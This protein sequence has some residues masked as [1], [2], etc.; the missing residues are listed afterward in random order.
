MVRALGC[1]TNSIWHNDVS[2]K[3]TL[4]FEFASHDNQQVLLM[5]RQTLART[6]RQPLR[7]FSSTAA[8]MGVTKK[9]IKQGNGDKPKAGDTITMEYTGNL[10]DEK[11]AANDYKGKQFVAHQRPTNQCS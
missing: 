5:I 8:A 1:G 6:L 7:Q 11:Q 10:Y 2:S 9:V 3:T 4:D